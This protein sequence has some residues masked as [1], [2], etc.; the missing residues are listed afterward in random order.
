MPILLHCCCAPCSTSVI[1]RLNKSYKVILFFFNPNI[2]P[3]E[4]Y[5]IREKEI[6][7]YAKTIGLDY[8][9]G[10]YDTDLWHRLIQKKAKHNKL[11]CPICIHIRL[12]ETAKT[13]KKLGLNKFTSTLT[14]SPHKDALMINRLGKNVDE[15]TGISYLTANFK[16]N[17]G[18]KRS[19]ELS[20]KLDMYRQNYCGC[21]FSKKV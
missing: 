21:K 5:F 9:V 8:Y 3:D 11:R 20:K 7:K 12:L 15:R 2:H 13:A 18:F 4:E 19:V 14:V 6:K 1:E 10:N 16:K 17:D